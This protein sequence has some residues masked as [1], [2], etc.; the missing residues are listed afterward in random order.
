MV[1]PQV[2]QTVIVRN[3]PAL[4]RSFDEHTHPSMAATLRV[5][6]E[7]IDGWPHP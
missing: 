1:I 7:Y 6:V 3:H 5:Q 4:V 2:G